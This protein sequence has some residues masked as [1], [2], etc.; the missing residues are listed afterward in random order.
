MKLSE[1]EEEEEEEEEE[2]VSLI[3][4]KKDANGFV[5][6][7]EIEPYFKVA[8]LLASI[9]LDQSEKQQNAFVSKDQE[10]VVGIL[11]LAEVQATKVMF[12]LKVVEASVVS[13]EVIPETAALDA[14]NY[15]KT[16]INM[17]LVY[18]DDFDCTTL[19]H[20]SPTPSLIPSPKHTYILANEPTGVQNQLVE[21]S[22]YE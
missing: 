3:R 17:N 19:N 7:K 12:G 18:E 13:E 15:G 14:L 4:K 8:Q 9:I 6:K 16:C 21:F 5:Q 11:E 1:I 10:T 22:A 20:I 2:N